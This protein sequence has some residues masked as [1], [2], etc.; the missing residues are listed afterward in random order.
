[1]LRQTEIITSVSAL[2]KEQ[3]NYPVYSDETLEKF[4][5]PC[6]FIKLVR[7]TDTRTVN[8]NQNQL[9]I[10]I[11]Y[12]SS[13]EK[14]KEIEFL[15]ITDDFLV[16]FR[17]GFKTADRYL[18]VSD[19]QSERIG[20]KADILQVMLDITY[21]DTTDYDKDAGYDTATEIILNTDKNIYE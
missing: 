10:I 13:S 4:K 8:Y 6:F 7:R 9:S 18:K 17:A 19:I 5:Q 11:T 1:M 21:H 2:L 12:F 3:F 15:D 14:N 16:L 20:E